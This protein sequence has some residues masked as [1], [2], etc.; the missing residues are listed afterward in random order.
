MK[1]CDN[2]VIIQ[3][4]EKRTRYGSL[5]VTSIYLYTITISYCSVVRYKN[6][7]KPIIVEFHKPE[8]IQTNSGYYFFRVLSSVVRTWLHN[9]LSL[10]NI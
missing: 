10:E 2:V 1:E 4:E 6:I 5:Y 3:S 7:D 9:N 8:V